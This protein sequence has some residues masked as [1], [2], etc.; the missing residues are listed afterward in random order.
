METVRLT[1]MINAPVERC[2]RLAISVD[3]ELRAAGK[4]ARVERG[5]S[6]GLLRPGDEVSYRGLQVGRRYTI[7][8]DEWR[9]YT[10][11][12]DV[13]LDGAFVRFEHKHHF[14]T[15]DDG[16]WMREEIRFALGFSLLRKGRERLVRKRVVRFLAARGA[17]IK[18]AAESD[19][20][21]EFLEG[22]PEIDLKPKMR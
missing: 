6:S 22:Q 4:A 12:R 19:G 5:L 13:R 17:M 16:T 18:Q 2:F 1:T 11:F 15:M 9:P 3:V 14:T 21:R 10:Y 20:W 7:L 8:V